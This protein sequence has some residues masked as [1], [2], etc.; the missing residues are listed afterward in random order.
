MGLLEDL[1]NESNFKAARRSWC[2]VCL[3][4]TTIDKAEAKALT[5]R[6]QDK[7]VANTALSRVLKAN[8]HEISDGTL[9]RH[10]RGE[11]QGV[12]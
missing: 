3:L 7:H 11:C 6:L 12:A 9:S 1:G 8:G 2:S 4:L 5:E 10:R